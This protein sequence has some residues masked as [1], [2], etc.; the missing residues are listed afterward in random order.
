MWVDVHSA[1]LLG[2]AWAV[3]RNTM[4]LPDHVPTLAM[5]VVDA[6]QRASRRAHEGMN[7]AR[8]VLVD[9]GQILIRYIS[10]SY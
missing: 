4:S 6:K 2:I 9:L 1:V 10:V 8:P 3:H 7:N 5:P